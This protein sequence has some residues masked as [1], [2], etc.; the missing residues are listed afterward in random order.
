MPSDKKTYCTP[1]SHRW[2]SKLPASAAVRA[3]DLLFISGQ[4]SADA[5]LKPSALGDVKAQARNAFAKIK[6]LVT[7]AGGSITG[8]VIGTSGWPMTLYSPRHV[9]NTIHKNGRW[10]LDELDKLVPISLGAGLVNPVPLQP[11]REPSS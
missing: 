1:K 8:Q 10:T 4:V 7:E 2:S 6:A 9:V 3:G 11:P 5:N